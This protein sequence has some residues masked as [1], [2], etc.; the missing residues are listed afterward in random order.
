[1]V[2]TACVQNYHTFLPCGCR[3]KKKKK[4]DYVCIHKSLIIFSVYLEGNVIISY[5]ILNVIH[6]KIQFVKKTSEM[7]R[8][9]INLIDVIAYKKRDDG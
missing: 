4:I 9:N 8:E 7:K 6:T 2:A 5:L 3:L 1:M